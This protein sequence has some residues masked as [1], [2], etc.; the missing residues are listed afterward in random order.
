VNNGCGDL[1]RIRVVATQEHG[2]QAA[3]VRSGKVQGQPEN[4]KLSA[5]DFRYLRITVE[6]MG[7]DKPLTPQECSVFSKVVLALLD[8]AEPI[9]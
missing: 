5:N 9:E 6:V 3:W 1:A 2:A 4:F 8:R 7:S